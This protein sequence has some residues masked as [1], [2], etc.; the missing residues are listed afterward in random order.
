M[1]LGLRWPVLLPVFA[2]VH[3]GVTRS[4]PPNPFWSINKQQLNLN[5]VGAHSAKSQRSVVFLHN[6][7][8]HF[9]Y[10]AAA[11]QRRG[12]DAVSVSLE[13]PDSANAPYYHGEDIN[14]FD[15]D[16]QKFK[17]N[18]FRFYVRIQRNYRMVHFSG[19]GHMGLFPDNWDRTPARNR[20]PWDFL[21]LKRHGI[22]IGYTVCGCND[23]MQPESFYRWSNGVCNKCVWQS[24]PDICSRQRNRNWGRKV[25]MVCD[26]VAVEA[27]AA[28][29]YRKG[30]HYYREPLTTCLDPDVWH[31]DIAIPEHRRIQRSIGELIVYHSVG[32]YQAR[33]L[34]SHNIKGT[35]AVLAAVER[36]KAEGM[37]VRMEFVTNVPSREVRFVQVQTDVVVD[38]IN[39]GRY[40]AIAREAMML[41][42][43]TICF[44]NPTQE[45]P[46]QPLQSLSECPLVSAT[47]ASIYEVL[48]D[49]LLSPEKRRAIGLASRDYALKW[50]SADACARRYEEVY[51]R[52]MQGL[53]AEE[54]GDV[55]LR[56]PLIL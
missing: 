18:L 56:D 52:I 53:P 8:Y 15:A 10:L 24:R 38:Q 32:N 42:K 44:I 16:P 6:S 21:A 13:S 2:R 35:S 49:L 25:D 9:Y 34:E 14:L 51:D 54:I 19:D 27:D 17:E 3:V 55:T 31:P 7:Y 43:P 36:L 1:T 22:K 12:W 50:H 11:L 5:K 45:P 39:Y 30:R 47:E 46:L 48:K 23:G 20:I 40:G 26:L 29:D 28:L 41:G 37:P 33:S 4:I